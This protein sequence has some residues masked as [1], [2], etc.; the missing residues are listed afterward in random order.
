M[1]YR[2]HHLHLLCSDL[3]QMENFFTQDLGA[4]LVERRKFGTADGA[5]LDL[6]GI[7][8]NLRVSRSDD[9]IGGDSSTQRYGY[10]HL[11][12]AVDNLEAAYRA[13][14]GKGYHFIQPP[15]EQGANKVAF[16]KGPDSITIELIQLGK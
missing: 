12:L 5:T 3:N 2:Y 1:T 8:I 4:K 6:K 11:G 9:V 15:T 13:L 16:L 14:K 10:D 7:T